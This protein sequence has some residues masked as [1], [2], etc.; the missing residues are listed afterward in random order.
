MLENQFERIE[1]ID[2]LFTCS[3]IILQK[4]ISHHQPSDKIF[5]GYILTNNLNGVRHNENNLLL[6][7]NQIF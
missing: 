6:L 7:T 4:D 1:K 5:K 2:N 3:S